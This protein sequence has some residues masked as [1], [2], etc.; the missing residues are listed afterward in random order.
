MPNISAGSPKEQRHGPS[1]FSHFGVRSGWKKVD[2]TPEFASVIGAGGGHIPPCEKPPRYSRVRAHHTRNRDFNHLFLAQE[3]VAGKQRNQEAQCHAPLTAVG[4]KLLRGGDPP[5]WAAEFSLDG[6]YLAVAG[7]SRFLTVFKVISTKEERKAQE[8]A[9]AH[10]GSIAER[11]SVPVF[12]SLPFREFHGHAGD[13]LALSWSKNNFLLST[14]IDKTVRLWHP[15][16]LDCLCLLA[17]DDVVTSVAFHPRDDRF[18]LAGSL[19]SQLRL[20]S[21]PDRKVVHSALAGESIT[22]VAFT[23]D[24]KFAIC[25]LLN[26]ICTFFDTVG[27]GVKYQIYARSSRAK[28]TKSCKVTGI[29]TLGIPGDLGSQQVKVLITSNDSRVR[30][31]DLNNKLPQAKFKGLKNQSSQ[32]HAHFSDDGKYIICGSED[33]NAYIWPLDSQGDEIKDELPYEFFDAHP[34]VVTNALMAPAATRQLLSASGD[35]I[36]D[37]CNP[38]PVGLQ[39][40]EECT[41]GLGVLHDSTHSDAPL[42]AR[43]PESSAYIDRCKH[44]NGHIIV[45]TDRAGTIQVFRQD[46]AYNNQQ[47]GY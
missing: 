38:P 41:A 43:R 40:L 30:V 18:F 46:C 21:I 28:S 44:S 14:A 17:H 19:D 20:W 45:T 29:Q 12:Q 16:R 22:A 36:Y 37:L 34:E 15:S 47:H 5:I 4:N 33:R 23:P 2:D 7:K 42:G 8:E 25:G 11:L 32:I 26:G 9:E 10:N 3:L 27:L 24:G 13:V 6:Q 35:P 39:N 1:L 31:Y